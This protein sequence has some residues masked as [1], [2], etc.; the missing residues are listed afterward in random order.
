MAPPDAILGLTEAFNND[1]NPEKINL[2]VGVYKDAEGKTPILAAVKKA[3]ERLLASE[4]TKSYLPID[5]SAEYGAAVQALLFGE[6]HEIIAGKRAVTAHTPGGTGALR[7]AADFAHEVNPKANIW[8]SEPTWPNH[9]GVFKA[10][11]ITVKTYPY[12]DSNDK[13]IAFDRMCESLNQASEGD[14]VLFHG[15]CHNPSGMDPSPEQWKALADLTAERKLVP[16]LD[17]AYQGFG[18]GIEEDAAGLR[19]FC[20]K[21]REL[22]IASSFSK[23]FGLYRERVGALTVVA[24]TQ[25]AAAAVRSNLKKTIRVNYSNP[26]AHGGGIVTTVLNDPA[27]RAEWEEEVQTMRSRIN[28]MRKL[29]VETLKKNGVQQD[30]SFLTRQRGMFSFSGLTKD[31][32]LQLRSECAIYIVDSG[33]IN[34]AGLTEANMP[35]LCKAVA[36]VL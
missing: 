32:V 23:N 29:F 26:P 20:G 4:S 7:V 5:G 25:S 14:I 8:L 19:Q 22:I 9:P 34:V 36:G 24:G 3:E 6:G 13:C 18:S 27:L 31:Q 30:F 12:Y 15:C 17:F 33:R 28:T 11:G 21:G 35:A 10:A 2:T 1:S 16:F